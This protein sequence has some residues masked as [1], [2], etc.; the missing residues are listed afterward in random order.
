LKAGL[1]NELIWTILTEVA[2]LF[3]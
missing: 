2:E 1:S 3:C